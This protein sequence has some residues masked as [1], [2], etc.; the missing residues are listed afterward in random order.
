[1]KK[2]LAPKVVVLTLL[3]IAV[4]S[5]VLDYYLPAMGDDLRFW[6]FLGLE[7]YHYPDRLTL[8]FIGGHVVGCNGRIFDYVG[9]IIINMLPRLVAAIVM[10]SMMGLYFYTVLL[11][12][13]IPRQ[14]NYTAFTLLMLG[15]TLAAM[16]WWD[17][18]WLRVCQFNY[19]WATTAGLLFVYW[20]FRPNTESKKL[21]LILLFALGI[22]A[23]GLHEQVGVSLCGAFFI[24]LVLG[25]GYKQLS[26]IRKTMVIG[27]FIGVLFPLGSPAFW[28][29]VGSDSIPDDT[30]HLIETTI[31]VFVALLLVILCCC[32]NAKGRNYLRRSLTD[33]YLILLLAATFASCI[34]VWSGIPGRTGW[35]VESAALV[36][37]ARMA[38]KANITTNKV[39]GSAA[40]CL[41]LLFIVSHYVFTIQGQRRAYDEYTAMRELYLASEDGIVYYDYTGRYDFPFMA[42]NR[43]KGV[44]D[45][46]DRWNRFVLGEA[47]RKEDMPLRILPAKFAGQ[48]PIEGD[49]LTIGTTT[50]YKS[51]P[52]NV[53]MTADTL[54]LQPWQGGLR[55]VEQIPYGWVA[56]ELVLDPGDYH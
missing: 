41:A 25:K 6:H 1:M 52:E 49:S 15:A 33:Q 22:A 3:F 23:G 35:F 9:P 29:R 17:A 4:C 45:S 7:D 36:I 46:D 24:W 31:P 19:T 42:F 11:S 12:A 34:A 13:K 43:I 21:T 5:A 56:T 44:P 53:E 28:D 50:V 55:V 32:V 54:L 27:L 30:I 48:L 47:Y 8:K 26:A 40:G 20:F 14:S 10:G 16:P 2:F 18:M 39:M 37:L 38:V 51:R